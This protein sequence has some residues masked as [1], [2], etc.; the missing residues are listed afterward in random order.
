MATTVLENIL[1]L[2]RWAPSGDNSQPWRFEITSA[3]SVTVHGHDTREHCVYDFDG[4]PS[5]ISLGA[6]LET[7]II[8]ASGY[9]MRA[10]ISPR[11]AASDNRPTFDIDLIADP[12]IKA[13]P[14]LPC[15]TERTV[16]RR[17]MRMTA[18]T[19][20][21]KTHLEAAVG[22]GYRVVWRE[23][24]ADRARIALLLFRSA[25]IR[26]TMPEAYKVHRDVIKF[27]ARFS[28]D[29][30][31]D[32]A[33]GL[34]PLATLAMRWMMASWPRIKFFNS[35]FGGTLLPR[36]ELDLVPGFACAAHFAIV[37]AQPSH[38]ID[39]FVSAGSAVQ[40]FWL[41][42][43][44]EKLFIQPEMTPLIFGWYVAAARRFSTVTSL[45]D[46]AVELNRR[47]SS[48]LGAEVAGRAIFFGRI[49]M[50]SPPVA[51]SL[52]LPLH[53]LTGQQR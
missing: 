11:R 47:W 20:Q 46:D 25:R 33:L 26:L 21:Q 44:R 15:I 30:I 12:M 38:S 17:A 8:A 37:P 52:R 51:R 36:I 34:D 10:Q 31:P 13:S 53:I 27:G 2:A 41:A 42:A 1:D 14:L 28:D 24:P 3:T 32:Q 23:S 22:A 16:Q 39:D 4:R 40:R 5:Q 50:G 19:L 6:L 29:R 43:T 48:F 18:L 9:G 7:L 49:G 35:Y 45:W